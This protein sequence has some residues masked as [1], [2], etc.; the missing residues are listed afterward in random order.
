MK[1]VKTIGV[2]MDYITVKQIEALSAL[3]GQSTSKVVRTLVTKALQET[4]IKEE[5]E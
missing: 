5:E 3:T 4:I 2:R 1:Y